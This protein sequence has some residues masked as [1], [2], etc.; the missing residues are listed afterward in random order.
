MPLTLILGGL[1]SGKTAFALSLAQP[2]SA[3][4]IY[5]ATAEPFDQEMAEKI[6]RHKAERGQSWLTIEAPLELAETLRGL[7]AY[8][9]GLGLIDGLGIWLA[10]LFAKKKDYNKYINEFLEELIS[11]PIPLIVV[12]DET[13]LGGISPEPET[14]RWQQALGYLNQQLAKMSDQVILVIAGIPLWIKG[15][16]DEAS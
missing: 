3:P 7:R 9:S 13:G 10:N 2:F 8:R 11:L 1:S 14:R 4:K 16:R 6:A 15:G 5:I 12:S